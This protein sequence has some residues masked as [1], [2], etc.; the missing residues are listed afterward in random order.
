MSKTVYISGPIVGGMA[1]VNPDTIAENKA[2]FGEAEEFFKNWYAG[3]VV[4]NPLNVA[5]CPNGDC[6]GVRQFGDHTWACY[7][8]Y[9]LIAMVR[10]CNAIAM[11]PGW[12]NSKG[13]RLE[14]H[15]A[16]ELDFSIRYFNRDMTDLNRKAI[17]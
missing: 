14:L 7:L 12:Q 10:R 6:V 3:W 8:R 9:D 13:A 5:A 17:L 15:V 4:V 16:K 11:I 1:T 2:R